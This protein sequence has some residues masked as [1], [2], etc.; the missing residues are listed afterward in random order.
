MFKLLLAV[1][2]QGSPLSVVDV[3]DNGRTARLVPSQ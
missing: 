2:T 3:N 1:F